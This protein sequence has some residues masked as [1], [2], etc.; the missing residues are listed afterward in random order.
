M[1]PVDG[2]TATGPATV[3]NNRTSAAGEEPAATCAGGV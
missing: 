1:E 3:S 2:L